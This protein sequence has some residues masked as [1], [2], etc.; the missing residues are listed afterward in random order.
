[1][2]LHYIPVRRD[3]MGGKGWVWVDLPDGDRVMFMDERD[4]VALPEAVV[5]A[6]AAQVLDD[7]AKAS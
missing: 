7:T 4:G 3:A 1:M 6:L 2:M 5:C